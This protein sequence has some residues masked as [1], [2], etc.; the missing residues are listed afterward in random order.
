VIV[1]VMVSVSK[2]VAGDT[3]YLMSVINYPQF[4]KLKNPLV[5]QFIGV[6]GR[7]CVLVW[8]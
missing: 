2:Q 4:F 8:Q 5:S 6:I 7:E 3:Y 1:S